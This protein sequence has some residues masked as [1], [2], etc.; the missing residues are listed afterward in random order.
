MD[1]LL[2]TL[3]LSHHRVDWLAG[4]PE[5]TRRPDIGTGRYVHTDIHSGRCRLPVA[6]SVLLFINLSNTIKDCQQE[7]QEEKEG[8]EKE[9]RERST[10]YF[11][12]LTDMTLYMRPKLNFLFLSDNIVSGPFCHSLNVLRRLLHAQMRPAHTGTGEKMQ[13]ERYE[14]SGQRNILHCQLV[15]G[16][17][18]KQKKRVTCFVVEKRHFHQC[19]QDV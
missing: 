13:R 6:S 14:R 15:K 12:F 19:N 9:W 11:F 7:W 5:D 2:I 3:L 8:E 17:P 18:A 4:T 10:P 1:K 16:T